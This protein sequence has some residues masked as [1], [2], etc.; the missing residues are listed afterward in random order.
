MIGVCTLSMCLGLIHVALC[1]AS[2]LG[3]VV[4][5]IW[6]AIYVAISPWH[7][8]H[9]I[10]R[11]ERN[12]ALHDLRDI[13]DEWRRKVTR[14]QQTHS[15]SSRSL[16]RLVSDCR[17]LARQYEDDLRRLAANAEA[18]AH[19]RYLRLH[20]IADA[21]ILK[22]GPVRKQVLLSYGISTAADV[23]YHRVRNIK[24]FG[25][26]LTSSLMAWKEGI[27][28]QFRF[29]PATDVSPAEQRAIAAKFKHEQK[30]MLDELS[31]A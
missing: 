25:H 14:Y 17:G 22:I 4:F 16:H 12:N 28:S 23:D 31:R 6:L 20:L 18:M 10:R 24:N 1:L 8:E 15:E 13:E 3:V 7:R 29:N 9:R 19:V 21:D 27:L 5:G 11:N 2:F 26:V 30:Q